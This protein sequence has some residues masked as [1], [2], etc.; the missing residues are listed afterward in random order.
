[1][2]NS[3]NPHDALMLPFILFL[4]SL[5][6]VASSEVAS[7]PS[8]PPSSSTMIL[9]TWELALIIGCGTLALLMCAYSVYI[10]MR[11]RRVSKPLTR[12]VVQ[13]EEGRG[14]T[15]SKTSPTK[16]GVKKESE[17]ARPDTKTV[18]TKD[19][20][21]G[22]KTEMKKDTKAVVTKDSKLGAKMEMKKDTKA[23]VTKDSKLGAKMDMKKETKAVVTKDPKPAPKMENESSAGVIAV[24][25]QPNNFAVACPGG[26]KAC[27]GSR[28]E[29]VRT[30]QQPNRLP[31]PRIRRDSA[32]PRIVGGRNKVPRV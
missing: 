14:K 28:K 24:K 4:C 5:A 17:E 26:G 20:K 18:V 31:A 12:I 29:G 25:I 21:L 6:S 10:I 23:V 27:I 3:T 13:M 19:S 11:R 32:P 30:I 16:K 8:S 9:E 1:M 2:S 15:V 7:P 22:A